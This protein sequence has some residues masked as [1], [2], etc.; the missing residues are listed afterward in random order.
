MLVRRPQIGIVERAQPAQA[1]SLRTLESI[2]EG[3][4]LSAPR[5]A[6]ALRGAWCFQFWFNQMP[7]QTSGIDL[8]ALVPAAEAAT[9]ARRALLRMKS[10]DIDVGEAGVRVAGDGWTAR[11]LAD[12]RVRCG[13]RWAPVRV[14]IAHDVGDARH[15]E[16]L[17]TPFLGAAEHAV[18]CMTKEWLI[19]EKAAL[20]VTYGADHTRVQDILDLWAI[21][22]SAHFD[23]PMLAATIQ[24]VFRGRDAERM[25]A[26][27]DSYWEG[28]LDTRRLCRR[29]L[30][31]WEQLAATAADP[32]HLPSLA[33][34][35]RQVS[36]FLLPMLAQL[37]AGSLPTGRWSHVSGWAPADGDCL[38]TSPNQPSL[39]NL[40]SIKLPRHQ[41]FVFGCGARRTANPHSNPGRAA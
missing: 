36:E 20:L 29:E 7:R 19:A 24:T 6:F 16:W 22:R 40:A 12:V 41:G 38:V 39:P 27:R 33:D 25:L 34:A 1:R 11:T 5:D 2:L 21:Q 15:V 3:L 23:A 14:S 30:V 13:E 28:A 37:R 18:P 10:P 32:P 35:V 26:R 17:R 4:A 8:A 31:A 9:M